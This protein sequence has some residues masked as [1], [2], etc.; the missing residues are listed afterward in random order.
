MDTV[1]GARNYRMRNFL[2]AHFN[3]HNDAKQGRRQYGNALR[4]T[5][6]FYTKSNK[7]NLELA[8]LRNMIAGISIRPTI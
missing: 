2:A 6:L 5:I 4:D 3:A 8:V 1:F 7:W